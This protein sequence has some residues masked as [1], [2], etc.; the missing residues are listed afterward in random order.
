VGGWG[1]VV[2]GAIG[3][4]AL[5]I[6]LGYFG[7]RQSLGNEGG[8]VL[9]VFAD[10]AALAAWRWLTR[11]QVSDEQAPLVQR[12]FYALGLQSLFTAGW[13]LAGISVSSSTTTTDQLIIAALVLEALGGL[14]V[15]VGFVGLAGSVGTGRELPHGEARDTPGEA[16]REVDFSALD[17]LERE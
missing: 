10:G 13:V 14:A 7:A 2:I 3:Y 4:V 6:H 5:L 15:F 17:D 9:P 16:P 11:L 8:V 1:L 12:A